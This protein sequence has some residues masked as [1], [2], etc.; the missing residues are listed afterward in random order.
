MR[1]SS[2]TDCGRE[3]SEPLLRSAYRSSVQKALEANL[4]TIAFPAISCGVFGYPFDEAAAA[5]LNELSSCADGLSEVAFCLFDKGAA[6]AYIQEAEKRFERAA[7]Q[8]A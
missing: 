6:D 4:K 7:D 5:S 3:S 2:A 1:I 8:D